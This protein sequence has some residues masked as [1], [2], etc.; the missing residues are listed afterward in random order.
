MGTA[1]SGTELGTVRSLSKCFYR[2]QVNEPV[3]AEDRPLDIVKQL[4]S[5][6]QEAGQTV[7]AIQP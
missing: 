1:L 4:L 5:M 7:G 6:P 2:D 3:S